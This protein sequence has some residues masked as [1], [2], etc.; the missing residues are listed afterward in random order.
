MI[1]RGADISAFSQYPHEREVL[2]APLT[3]LE[4]H[5]MHVEDAVLVVGVSPSI[6]LTALT[7]EQVIGK[8]HKL[9]SDMGAGMRLEVQ[10]QLGPA[11]GPLAAKLLERELKAGALKQAPEAYNDDAQFK[12]AVVGVLDAKGAVLSEEGRLA[13][14]EGRTE[15]AER[16]ASAVAQ[17]REAGAAAAELRVAGVAGGFA[18]AALLQGG[19]AV[20]ALRAKDA[21]GRAAATDRELRAAGG[22]AA[23]MREG[24]FAQ[25]CA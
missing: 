11:V 22:G 18:V 13:M 19:Y 6:N 14:M 5:G 23:E 15:A 12:A 25:E 20:G 2:L 9:L 3:G 8:R 24:G 1:D 17:L 16:D 4:V 10:G 21:R 7:I